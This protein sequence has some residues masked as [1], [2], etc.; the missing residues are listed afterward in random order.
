[1]G[2]ATAEKE[3]EEEHHL[4]VCLGFLRAPLWGMG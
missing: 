3:E 2:A 4:W 1:M